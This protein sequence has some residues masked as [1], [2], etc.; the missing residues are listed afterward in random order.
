MIS[1]DDGVMIG[2]GEFIH[3]VNPKLVRETEFL[4]FL[5][6]NF[7]DALKRLRRKNRGQ[8]RGQLLNPISKHQQQFL[9]VEPPRL[10]AGAVLKSENRRRLRIRFRSPIRL[11]LFQA[12][13]QRS[14]DVL[15]CGDNILTGGLCSV[16]LW[17]QERLAQLESP[18]NS[19][20]GHPDFRAGANE[21]SLPDV[22][23][24]AVNG[25]LAGKTEF[26]TNRL[27]D[28]N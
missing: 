2:C 15:N 26:G 12:A 8:H 28:S 22:L 24:Q 3:G 9:P 18:D 25:E 19:R 14:D 21:V 4:F 17:T 23:L 10:E 16:N 13:E 6:R 7:L 1:V 20:R 11:L 27:S 5:L